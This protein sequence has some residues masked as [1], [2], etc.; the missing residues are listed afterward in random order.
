MTTKEEFIRNTEA[1]WATDRYKG[2]KRPY[3]AE[4]VWSLRGLFDIE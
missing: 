3:S 2:I 4:D 1:R